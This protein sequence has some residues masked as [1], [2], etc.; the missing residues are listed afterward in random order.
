MPTAL[1]ATQTQFKLAETKKK[2]GNLLTLGTGQSREKNGFRHSWI[3]GLKWVQSS[4]S[5]H[6][7]ARPDSVDRQACQSQRHQIH[8]LPAQQPQKKE[9]AVLSV[10]CGREA[11]WNIWISLDGIACPFLNESLWSGE[12]ISLTGQARLHSRCHSRVWYHDRQPPRLQGMVQGPF[13]KKK[14]PHRLVTCE[15]LCN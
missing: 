9:T 5:L 11:L 15:S 6:G 8:S 14:G 13:T 2:K 3:Q 7:L 12:W 10:G 4:A 1:R